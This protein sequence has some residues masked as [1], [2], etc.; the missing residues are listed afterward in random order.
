MNYLSPEQRKSDLSAPRRRRITASPEARSAG[1]FGFV[2]FSKRDSNAPVR[3]RQ[4]CVC[5]GVAH[6]VAHTPV[7]LAVAIRTYLSSGPPAPVLT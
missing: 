3:E 2:L 7:R 4:D 5:H 1:L 6:D